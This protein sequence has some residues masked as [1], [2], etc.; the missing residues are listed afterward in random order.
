MPATFP[1]NT[2]SKDQNTLV[3]KITGQILK[4]INADYQQDTNDHPII[5]VNAVKNIIGD[6]REDPSEL[7]LNFV[8]KYL[9]TFS[10]RENDKKI[11]EKVSKDGIGLTMFVEDIE[12][13]LSIRDRKNV[14]ELTAKLLLASD[15][16]PATLEMLAELALLAFD[17]LGPFTFHWLR[18]YQFHQDKE[19]QWPYLYSMINELFKTDIVPQSS[20]NG[21]DKQLNVIQY[22]N[23]LDQS[24]WLKLS[25]AVRL[26]NED[27]VR[28]EHYNRSIISWI[29]TQPKN[30]ELKEAET[31][32]LKNYIA[33]GGNYF[34]RMAKEIVKTND[35]NIARKKIVDLEALRGMAKVSSLE[36]FPIITQCINTLI[37]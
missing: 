15:H 33:N 20:K 18:S 3:I 25:A 19:V 5:L 36:S 7:L 32:T 4:A 11:L 26:Y 35:P 28:S 8:D 31:H 22:V 29:Q 27:Y 1:N 12:E 14:E 34:N 37:Q 6:D 23:S 13:A 16:S 2:V 10:P 30:D 9:N 17:K 21:N 24:N